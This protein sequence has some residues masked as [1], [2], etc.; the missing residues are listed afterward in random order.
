MICAGK[1]RKN[2]FSHSM[3]SCIFFVNKHRR[4]MA[5]CLDQPLDIISEYWTNTVNIPNKANEPNPS[6]EEPTP[7]DRPT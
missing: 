6:P 4:E 3:C 2:I 1:Q 5:E 7:K